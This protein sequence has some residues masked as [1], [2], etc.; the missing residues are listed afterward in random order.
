MK[1]TSE[2]DMWDSEVWRVV[3]D[4]ITDHRRWCVVHTMILERLEDNTFWRLHLERGATEYQDGYDND[5]IELTPV[6]PA[7]KW[8]TVYLTAEEMKA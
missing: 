6:F 8:M 4:D 1:L 3:Q 2:D 5:D 7:E